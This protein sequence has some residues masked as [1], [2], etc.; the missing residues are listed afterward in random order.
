MNDFIEENLKELANEVKEMENS[1]EKSR[2]FIKD[3]LA[4]DI[5]G[6]ENL[7]KKTDSPYRITD[8]Y[9]RTVGG[10][11]TC[12]LRINTVGSPVDCHR[13]TKA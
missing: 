13:G 11:C 5:Q 9:T 1:Y 12:P 4:K 6:I 8:I 2:I 3:Q 7:L 10:P